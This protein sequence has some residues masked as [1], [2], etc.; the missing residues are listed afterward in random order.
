[1]ELEK[2]ALCYWNS[3]MFDNSLQ[4]DSSKS[5][6]L[7]TMIE[8]ALWARAGHEFEGGLGGQCIGKGGGVLP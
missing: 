2:I 6:Q 7:K 8:S 5:L 1:M 3:L 4:P